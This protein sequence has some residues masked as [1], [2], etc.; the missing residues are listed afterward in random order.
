MSF[1]KSDDKTL[2]IHLSELTPKIW[3]TNGLFSYFSHFL[4]IMSGQGQAPFSGLG[5]VYRYIFLHKGAIHKTGHDT[6]NYNQ[7]NEVFLPFH[8]QNP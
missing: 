3:T 5:Y 6:V 1:S 7:M 8:T 4:S 2:W